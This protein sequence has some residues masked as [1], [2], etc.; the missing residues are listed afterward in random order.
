MIDLTADPR[1][2]RST[3]PPRKTA[4]G[5]SRSN[6]DKHAYRITPQAL[7][8]RRKDR[9][10]T[11]ATASGVSVYGYRYYESHNGRWIS[12]DPIGENGGYNLYSFVNNDAVNQR[13]YLGLYTL[14]DAKNSL[15]KKGVEKDGFEWTGN[16]GHHVYTP[17]QVFNEWL[18][19]E[20]A[21]AAWL[22]GIPDC[23]DKICV[24]DGKP[25]NCDNGDWGELTNDRFVKKFHPNADYCMR[26]R[27]FGESAQQCCYE[28]SDDGKWLKLRKSGESA[29]TPDRVA[30]TGVLGSIWN[31]LAD[32]GHIGHD[33]T[34]F[35]QAKALGRINDY[36][37]VRLPSQGMGKCY[38]QQFR[39]CVFTGNFTAG[40]FLSKRRRIRSENT[41][42]PVRRS[43]YSQGKKR[44][45]RQRFLCQRDC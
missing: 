28:L 12:R 17:T 41:R 31:F 38:E 8:T 26:S 21:D 39:V 18:V 6:P 27:V 40:N 13:D 44:V 24:I 1:P 32:S 2:A 9:P 20:K 36:L 19:L 10:T 5:S 11:T 29:G 14:G 16:A 43:R 34:P 23:P 7:K 3:R 42:H 33:V 37:N 15:S 30:A 4:S 45:F 35:N 22:N 25:K